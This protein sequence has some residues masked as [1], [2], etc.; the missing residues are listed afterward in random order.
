M[1]WNTTS[2]TTIHELGLLQ[3]IISP[4]MIMNT[5]LFHLL[6][7]RYIDKYLSYSAEG[8]SITF[9]TTSWRYNWIYVVKTTIVFPMIFSGDMVIFSPERG[10]LGSQS[11][12]AWRILTRIIHDEWPLQWLHAPPRNNWGQRKQVFSFR[13]I[14]VVSPKR[15]K[16][17]SWNRT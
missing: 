17:E 15:Q 8:T 2:V 14:V 10:L 4:G 13:K 1:A 9:T 16:M 5:K 3:L 7:L 12:R 6:K 11:Y